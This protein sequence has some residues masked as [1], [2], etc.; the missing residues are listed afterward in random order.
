MTAVGTATMALSE[1]PTV[2]PTS[3]STALPSETATVGLTATASPV[4]TATPLFDT[5]ADGSFEGWTLP[6]GWSSDG[7]LTTDGQ[8]QE[9]G[10]AAPPVTVGSTNDYGVEFE[11]VL[12]ATDEC[13]RSFGAAIRGTSAGYIAGGVEWNC[14][15]EALIWIGQDRIAST[16]IVLEPGEHTMRVQAVGNQA[17]VF[18]D[19][20]VSIEATTDDVPSGDQVAFWSAG[21]PITI[22]SVRIVDLSGT[23]G[24]EGEQGD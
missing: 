22:T 9:V 23:E 13:P 18:I 10:W 15:A 16:A 24:T 17:T 19:G 2:Q 3:S 21:V 4:P 12:G 11:F 1:T 5:A 14:D 8:A 6:E 20:Q 7:A